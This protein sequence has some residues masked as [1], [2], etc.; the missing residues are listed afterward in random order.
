MKKWRWLFSILCFLP[1]ILLPLLSLNAGISGDEPVHYLQAENV[2]N[3]FATGGK[4]T[5]AIDTPITYLKYYGQSI[6]NFSYLVNR[7]FHFD[8]PYLSRHIINALAGALVVLFTG[9]LASELA[10]YGAGILAILFLLLSPVFLGHTL[11]NLKDIPFALG[12][13]VAIYYLIRFLRDLPRIRF[14][15]LAGMAAGTGFA[16]SVR[17][18]GILLIP[19]ILTFSLIQAWIKQPSED[20]EKSRFALKLVLA[21]FLTILA[22][23]IAG[24]IDWPYGLQK[25]IRHSIESLN[26]M[27]HY[28]VN[29]RQLF[30]GK[31]YWSETLPWYYAP[32]YFLMTTPVVIITGVLLIRPLIKKQGYLLFGL[33]LFCAFFPVCWVVIRHSNLYGNIRHLLFIYPFLVILAA[34]GWQFAWEGMQK[35]VFRWGMGAILFL[36]LIGPLVHIIRN[37]PVEYVYFNKTSGGVGGAFGH[38]ETDYYSHSLGPGVRWLEKAILSKPGGDTL[39]IASNFPLDP[40]FEKSFPGIKTVYTTWYDRGR[41][42]WDYGL[43]VNAYLAPSELQLNRWTAPQIIHTIDVD[44][45]PM[46][47]VLRRSDKRDLRGYRLFEAGHYDESAKLL[48]AVTIADP[49]NETAWLYLGWSLRK[50]NDY[51]GS[52]QAAQEILRQHPESEQAR[53]LL[54]WNYLNTKRFEQAATL[55]DELNRLNP[56]YP[57]ALQLM[58]ASQDSL[59]SANR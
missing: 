1:F 25:P 12:Y 39:V 55:A 50:L 57:P 14:G 35:P 3:Y 36:G 18:G 21:L 7:L 19:I 32:I 4:D 9:L 56:K 58:A 28:I 8:E 17:I 47:Q 44:G 5:S 43:F 29:L 24:I 42:D 15:Y 16:I 54:I 31:L 51:Q 30:E 38:Y 41:Y 48:R 6:D 59:K 40:F 2:Y 22:G 20:Q 53:E 23:C 26:Q 34:C 37:H 11:N 49:R 27:T 33:L 10:G 46:C 13:V 45:Y 52:E